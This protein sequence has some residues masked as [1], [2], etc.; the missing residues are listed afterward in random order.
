MTTIEKIRAEIAKLRL[1]NKNIKCKENHNYC[2]G[3]DDAFFDFTLFLDT[4]EAD[5]P[6][7]LEEEERKYMSERWKLGCTP[8]TPVCLPN[9]TTDDLKECAE[10]F[11]RL[12]LISKK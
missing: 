4:L 11:Y 9:F 10:F 12:G 8:I 3:Y 2:Q 1:E 5:A 6:E 7:W